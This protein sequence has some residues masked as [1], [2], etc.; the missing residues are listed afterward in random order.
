MPASLALRLLPA[1]PPLALGLTAVVLV[2][3]AVGLV[4]SGLGPAAYLAS[5]PAWI[6]LGM[7]FASRP[8]TDDDEDR[9]GPDPAAAPRDV[10]ALVALAVTAAR[11]PA[12][13]AVSVA[14]S[15]PVR[16]QPRADGTELTIG[17]GVLAALDDDTVVTLIA[18][19]LI[20]AGA[21]PGLEQARRRA[22][23]RLA[24]AHDRLHG[25]YG[26]LAAPFVRLARGLHG[27][28]QAVASHADCELD[29]QAAATLG[30]ARLARA[31]RLE[32]AV[33]IA[34]ET[35]WADEVE[36][37]LLHG[38]RPPLASGLPVF[39][40]ETEAQQPGA[41]SRLL[42]AAATLEGERARTGTR[43]A[44]LGG[45]PAPDLPPPPPARDLDAA[46]AAL[47]AQIATVPLQPCT[48]EEATAHATQQD[49]LDEIAGEHAWLAGV[50][51]EEVP[52]TLRA[53]TPDIDEHWFPD[54]RGPAL[55]ALL[56]VALLRSGWSAG[57]QPG[58][59]FLMRRG[60]AVTQPF[61]MGWALATRQ[62]GDHD[63]TDWCAACDV[64]AL[65]EPGELI[66]P[67]DAPPGP[68]STPTSA[69]PPLITS[70]AGG[71]VPPDELLA[72]RSVRLAQ[73]VGGRIVTAAGLLIVGALAIPVALLS[74]YVSAQMMESPAAGVV[75]GIIAVFLIA[76][77]VVVA[78]STLWEIVGRPTL[79]TDAAGDLIIDH[80]A[81]L[82]APLC[83]SR[84]DVL[85]V[86]VDTTGGD[87]RFAVTDPRRRSTAGPVGW[88]WR[89]GEP[90]PV[91]VLDTTPDR[92]NIAI[93]LRHA[94]PAPAP[95]G[96]AGHAILAGE[97]ID[98]LLLQA[99]EPKVARELFVALG[100][101]RPVTVDD[102]AAR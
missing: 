81:L 101:L 16:A 79:R 99:V 3:A 68:A 2:V 11:A 70:D 36:R 38:R 56:A 10:D 71:H 66:D 4:R 65:P 59:P 1:G 89:Y 28:A 47:A 19:E 96:R 94:V 33:S 39:L 76:L 12:P 26:G 64:H 30:A 55:L 20:A 6:A 15:G 32:S 34:W 14:L 58:A 49:W 51:L 80:P 23:G 21:D 44:R 63:F 35:Y 97:R 54:A 52:A 69:L 8:R 62:A 88:L 27:R 74:L 90:A 91:P 42:D 83:L 93:I 102:L 37:V 67:R 75:M 17:L 5:V 29:A 77:I 100:V 78:R 57:W 86:D 50:T 82:R 53:M 85:V 92:P 95:R 18:R 40:H 46:E 9:H 48:W 73:P 7:L 60:D 45:V 25:Q 84:D 13:S 87:T 31:L 43:V 22:I 72:E 24:H 98:G 61:S 41:W